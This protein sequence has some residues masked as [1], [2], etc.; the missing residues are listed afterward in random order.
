[1]KC[2]I[3]ECPIDYQEDHHIISKSKGGTNKK[4]NIAYLCAACH[5]KVHAGEI[6]LEGKFLT[7]EGYQLIYHN[8]GESS[9][10]GCSPDVYLFAM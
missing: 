9:I 4:F 10:T 7:S 5:H 1:M 2:E 6:I 8:K 3:K